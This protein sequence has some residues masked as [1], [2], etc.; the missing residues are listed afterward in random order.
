MLQVCDVFQEVLSAHETCP[1]KLGLSIFVQLR[2]SEWVANHHS[3]TSPVLSFADAVA[4]RFRLLSA[5]T[6]PVLREEARVK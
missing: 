5:T 2:A 4:L 6:W 1:K 3:L